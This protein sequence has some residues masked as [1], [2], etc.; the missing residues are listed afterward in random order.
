MEND[1]RTLLRELKKRMGPHLQSFNK[2]GRIY[3]PKVIRDEFKG[4]AFYIHIVEG[5]IVL[6][7][8]KIK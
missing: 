6:D 7:P 4:Y 5:K 3:I 2:E 8:V 1:L